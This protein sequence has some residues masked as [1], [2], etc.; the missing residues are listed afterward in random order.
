V[1]GEAVA[2][3][4]ASV[5]VVAEASA[6]S[7]VALPVAVAPAEAGRP[8]EK[9]LE[10][11]HMSM[12]AQQQHLLDDL[13][14]RLKHALADNLDSLVLYGSAAAKDD[15]FHPEYSDLNVLCLV[16]RLDSV[17]LQRLAPVI[18]WWQ[19]HKQPAAM[20]FTINELRCSADV[21]A[22]ELYDIKQRHRVLFGSDHFTALE[23]PMDLHR[24]AVE[25]ELRTN[26]IRLR[27]K[28]MALANNHDSKPVIQL[29]ADSV[30]S[31]AT[32]FRHSLIALGDQAPQHKREVVDHLADK[33]DFERNAFDQILD[34]REGKL[35][36]S[37]IDAQST[38]DSYL[39]AI[40][41]VVDEVDKRLG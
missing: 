15:G 18:A 25:R 20:I 33:L 37:D 4:E 21:F 40:E 32:L 17:T 29:M 10:K 36:E 24:V 26:L 6:V 41:R 12:N 38:F 34:L 35:R 13:L 39:R 7:V 2:V 14:A 9:W 30:S 8:G 22:I 3:A 16:K 1:V 27:Q 5:V 19:D 31:F 28:Y 11:E 23:V